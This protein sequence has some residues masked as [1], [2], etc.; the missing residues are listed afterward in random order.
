MKEILSAAA[1]EEKEEN[2]MA[3]NFDFIGFTYN[4]LHSY[5]DFKIY[6]IS[7]GSI[8]ND[9]LLPTMTD[10]TA[11]VPGGEGQYFFNTQHKAKQFAISIAFEELDEA[12]Y[13]DM[14]TWLDGKEIHDLIFDEHPYKV[15]SA[16]VTGTPQLKTL[17]FDD[18]NGQRV[19]K[20]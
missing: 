10:K 1:D 14:R 13:R 9:N 4:G 7:D 2:T 12:K 3:D 8:Y 16:K 18:E 5:T 11:D 20:G 6:R 19:Y 17:C 15:Y